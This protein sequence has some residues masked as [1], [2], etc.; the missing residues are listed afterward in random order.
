[1][2]GEAVRQLRLRLAA[3]CGSVVGSRRFANPHT[4]HDCSKLVVPGTPSGD[5]A[6]L[7]LM[8]PYCAHSAD[9]IHKTAR[10]LKIPSLCTGADDKHIHSAQHT[11]N[12]Q[13]CWR[14]NRGKAPQWPWGRQGWVC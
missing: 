7:P 3:P 10:E 8:A 4:L 9:V 12:M 2:V 5:T 6:L 11:M 1:M 14:R 13:N